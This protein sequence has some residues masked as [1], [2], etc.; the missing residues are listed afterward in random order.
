MDRQVSSLERRHLTTTLRAIAVVVLVGLIGLAIATLMVPRG[1]RLADITGSAPSPEHPLPS[2]SEVLNTGNFTTRAPDGDAHVEFR[3]DKPEAFRQLTHTY[4]IAP[5]PENRIIAAA[6]KSSD[7][8]ANWKDEAEAE[9]DSGSLAFDLRNA[10]AHKFWRMVITRSG[11]APEVVLGQLRFIK[12]KNFLQSMPVDAVWLGLIPASILVLVCF[13]IPL[14]LGRLFMATALPVALFVFAY[15]LAYVDSHIVLSPDS[16][17]YLKRIVD[18]S[19]SLIRSAGYSI[20]LL[21]V[22]KTAGLEHLAWVQLGAGLACYLTGAYLLAVRLGN[23]WFAPLLAFAV[24]LQGT[25]SQFAT[26]VLTESFFTAGLGLF[27]AALGALAWRPDRLAVVAAMVGIFLAVM[28]KSHSVVLVFPAL[29]LI[30]FVPKGLRLRTS[31]PIVLAGLA[32]YGFLT[33]SNFVRT[34]VPSPE[35][36]AGFALLSHVGWMLDDTSMPPSDLTRRMIDAAA[37][38]VAQ[39]PGDLAD[40]HS[41]ATLDRYVDLTVQDCN[42]IFW[43]KLYPIAGPELGSVEKANAFFLRFGISSIRAHPLAYVRHVAAHFYGMWRDLGSV[44]PLRGATAVARAEAVDIDSRISPAYPTLVKANILSPYPNDAV[45]MSDVLSQLDL[46]LW[47]GGV[48]DTRLF[49]LRSL[50][51]SLN[52]PLTLG[53]LALLLSVLFLIPGRLTQLYRTEIMIALCLNAFFGAHVLLQVTLQRY[54]AVGSL[55]AVFL[56]ISFILTSI[57]ALSSL[58]VHALSL[59][60]RAWRSNEPQAHH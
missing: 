41:L 18:G 21:A 38:V 56:A 32:T 27:A 49:N 5:R 15:S 23:R 14:T 4:R 29:L 30:R 40:I 11:D 37:P 3:Y 17:E 7:D 6:V 47:F 42:A 35:S 57:S 58:V 34:G 24:L 54:S 50:L 52:M 8:A 59:V 45:L 25:T 22:Q 12:D 2:I 39:R 28:T 19:W 16:N 9:G 10:G 36:F 1:S 55:A 26:D 46:P 53:V 44:Q 33:L 60:E 51:E 20:I 43:G 31:G 13:Q 48:W